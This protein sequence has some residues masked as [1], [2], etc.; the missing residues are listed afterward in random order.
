MGPTKTWPRW[1]GVADKGG[2]AERGP[3]RSED[4]QRP[5]RSVVATA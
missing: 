5:L 4:R 3:D 2:V 1:N